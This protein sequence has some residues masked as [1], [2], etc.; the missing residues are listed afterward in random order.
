MTEMMSEEPN[1]IGNLLEQRTSAESGKTFLLSEPDGRQFTYAE[2]D[3]AV[4]RAAALLAAHAVAKGDVVSLLMPNS[5][6][7]I[8]AYFAC[9]KLGAIAGPVNSLLKEHEIEFVMNNSEA[10]AIL[11]HS[12]FQR[13]I[14]TIRGDLP[15][16]RS[17]IEFDDEAEATREFAGSCQKPDSGVPGRAARLGWGG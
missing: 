8:I 11:V 1:N 2:F 13:R 12:E 14:E 15:R 5:A 7:Y 6:E 17:L 4:N 3:A 10:K 16:L 9:W